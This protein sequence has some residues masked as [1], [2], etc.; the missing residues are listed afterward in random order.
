MQVGQ[1]RA[2]TAAREL[3]ET[4]GILPDGCLW[5][6]LSTTQVKDLQKWQ[7]DSHAGERCIHSAGWRIVVLARRELKKEIRKAKKEMWTSWISEGREVWDIVRV[8][9][10]PFGMRERC[11]TLKDGAGNQYESR[12]E[13]LQAFTAHNLIIDPAEE[14][15]AVRQQQRRK[16]SE[17]AMTRIRHALKKTRNNSAP[18]PDGISWKLLKILKDTGVGRAV[19]EDAGQVAERRGTTRMPERWRAMKMVMIPKP[20]KDHT[21]V[22]GWRP[23]VLANVVGKLAEKVVAIELQR[24]KEL[25]HERAFAGR[26]G[27]GAIDSVMLMAHIAEK[28]QQGVIVGRDA[29]S[30]FNTVRREHMRQIL[31]NHGWLR[32]WIYD[33]LAPRQFTMEVDGQT[34]GSVTMTGGTPQGS[35]LSPALFTVYMSSV[36]WEAE[37]RL[38][39]RPGGRELRRERRESYWPLSYIDD[40]NGVR[41]GGEEEMDEALTAAAEAAGVRWDHDKDW[42]G[43]RGKHLGV[44]M[45]D[46][47][48]H[49]KY[50]SQKAKAAWEVVRRLSRMPAEGKRKILTQ[51][52]LPIL[53]YRCELYPDPSEQQR[54]LANELYRWVVGAYPGSRAD[55]VQALVGLQDIGVI[56][57]NK[58]IRWAAS[59]YAR[60]MPE[61]RAI[62]EPILRKAVGEEVELRWME[63]VSREKRLIQ[64][65]ELE[66]ERVEEWSDGSRIEG[67]AA[68]GTRREGL[69]LGEWATVADAE[70]VG[71]MLSWEGHDIVVLDS[72]GVIQRIM[73]LQY[74][75]PRS[76]IEERLVQQ[77]Q[78]RSRT[79]MWV[80]GHTGVRGNEE[81]DR[82][83]K[84][85]VEGSEWRCAAGIAT[86]WGIKQEFPIYPRAPAHISWN[87]AARRGLVYMVTD[88]GPQQQ[89]LWEIGKADTQWCV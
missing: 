76:W 68:G 57:L 82:R 12:E 33:W 74:E 52:L 54:R 20:G 65:E 31:Q 1:A 89:W 71:V 56:M 78:M 69:Y 66:E 67:K 87:T 5:P 46:Q 3:G 88:K 48:R 36:V 14:R 75:E 8:C 39:Q 22:K 70:E 21:A 84:R 64:I 49:Q 79:L 81:A 17:E 44:V 50:R 77:M 32:D 37:Q 61:L 42:R 18:G 53:T 41:I 45:Q 34:L 85:E 6:E 26:R 11:G 29:Q 35:P 63:G 83:A 2:G 43:N 9:K 60:H 55:K 38:R 86:P 58:R 16:P 19:I 80:R 73:N 40:V 62:A 59:V 13:K 72:Q 25:W 28:Y 23:I 30:A 51:Q 47:R 15:T 10:N 27:R 4:I 24:H 7:G